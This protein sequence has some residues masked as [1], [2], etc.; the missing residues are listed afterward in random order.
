MLARMP[1]P[2]RS[3]IADYFS[4]H[5]AHADAAR[6]VA[7]SGG[8]DSTVLLH[9]LATLPP[10]RGA[11]RAL[12]VDHGLHADST[13]W[14]E[15]CV[16]VAGALPVPLRVLEVRVDRVAGLG[17]EGAARHARYA[18]FNAALTGGDLLLTAHHADDQAE[19]LLLRA[20]RAAG[21]EGLAAM[22]PLRPLGDAWLGRPLLD[23]PRTAIEDYA[24]RHALEWIE[25]PSN[26]DERLDRNFLRHRVLPLIEQRW[27][28]ARRAL[29][30]SAAHLRAADLATREV[31]D[32]RLR[33]ALGGSRDRLAIA[34]LRAG[35][36]GDAM[37]LV[38]HWLLTLDLPPPPPRVL[39]DLLRQLAQSGA[40]RGIHV[41]WPG[42]EL[43]RYRGEL[44]ASRPSPPPAR[45]ADTA[46][47]L[48]QPLTIEGLGTLAIEGSI[49]A[50]A[51]RVAPRRGGE[52]IAIAANRPRR[53]VR[54]LFQE[55][56]I[57][58]LRRGRLPYV[59]DGE[60]LIAVGDVFIDH[61]F[62]HW[63]QTHG[64]R[65]RWTPD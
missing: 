7:F 51:L 56:A 15:H 42:A 8:L 14:A 12:H 9:A 63:L 17:P 54:L 49:P 19:T 34:A 23:L 58:P 28:K 5:A 55:H 37:L 64:A 43:R 10:S 26:V 50:R 59:F 18:A 35:G 25:D 41:R 21:V 13:R 2:V 4:L 46:W 65:L 62:R 30:H 53:A 24:R 27:P 6:V 20:L 29:A 61:D 57:A 47:R 32:R 45:F 60:R 36:D 44:F 3:A 38:R 39:G 1:C 40:D 52:S 31:L 16:R 33:D 48:P 22:R 11:L